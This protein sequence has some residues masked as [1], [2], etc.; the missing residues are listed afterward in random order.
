MIKF[1]RARK[2]LGMLLA[3]AAVSAALPAHAAYSSCS[4]TWSCETLTVPANSSHWVHFSTYGSGWF[5][6]VSR[7]R[8]YD[9]SNFVTV[10]SKAGSTN[11][12]VYGLYSRY[13]GAVSGFNVHA[14]VSS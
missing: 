2:A 9:V 1:K 7:S 4:G 5:N 10:Y 11:V 3:T 13:R 8:L 6:Y 12:Y 14:N